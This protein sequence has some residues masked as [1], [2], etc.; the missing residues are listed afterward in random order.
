MKIGLL[1]FGEV[2]SILSAG[3]HGKWGR[4]FYVI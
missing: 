4:M 2:A 1:G 3:T